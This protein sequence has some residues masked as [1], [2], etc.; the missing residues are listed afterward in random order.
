MTFKIDLTIYKFIL[1]Q[2]KRKP[3]V[4]CDQTKVVFKEALWTCDDKLVITS[5]YLVKSNEYH[6]KIRVWTPEGKLKHELNVRTII[7]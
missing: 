3:L 7:Y 5:I 4:T 6:N 2:K 1:I